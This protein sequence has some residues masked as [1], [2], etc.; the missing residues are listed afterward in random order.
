MPKVTDELSKNEFPTMAM[1]TLPAMSIPMS[2]ERLWFKKKVTNSEADD[3][4][5]LSVKNVI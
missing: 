3:Q 5:R 1:T 4:Q 2:K